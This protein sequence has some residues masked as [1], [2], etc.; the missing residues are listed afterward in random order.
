MWGETVSLSESRSFSQKL[1]LHLQKGIFFN[2]N[3]HTSLWHY[4]S[5]AG[6]LK[7]HKIIWFYQQTEAPLDDE[8]TFSNF[9]E[10]FTDLILHWTLLFP[11]YCCGV[12]LHFNSMH[13]TISENCRIQFI[14]SVCGY[15]P[16]A[17]SNHISRL[18]FNFLAADD[19]HCGL[20]LH[21]SS[22]SSCSSACNKSA[23]MNP[24][25]EDIQTTSNQELIHWSLLMS[26]ASV[27]PSWGKFSLKVLA[28]DVTSLTLSPA[29]S[30]ESMTTL[31]VQDVRIPKL[32]EKKHQKPY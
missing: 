13:S 11:N 20:D 30:E 1:L 25:S 16:G 17:S 29:K 6:F 3:T 14:L 32:Q 7:A 24:V 28:L 15:L 10:G 19:P 23:F 8:P 4:S 2:F 27:E 22:I 12:E 9:H 31:G 26:I 5:K 21:I 18:A